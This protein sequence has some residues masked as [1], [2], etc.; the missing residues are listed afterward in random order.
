MA[1]ALEL[2][3][4]EHKGTKIVTKRN[5]VPVL[6]MAMMLDMD[7]HQDL[8]KQ[9]GRKQFS[10]PWD[11][12]YDVLPLEEQQK[13]DVTVYQ[14]IYER[15]LGRDFV[16]EPDEMPCVQCDPAIAHIVCSAFTAAPPSV[17]IYLSWEELQKLEAAFPLEGFEHTVPCDLVR[18][19]EVP[20]WNVELVLTDPQEKTATFTVV[21][22]R[23]DVENAWNRGIRGGI[24][25]MF[26]DGSGICQLFGVIPG[27]NQLCI[28]TGAAPYGHGLDCTERDLWFSLSYLMHVWYLVQL[29]CMHPA[30]FASMQTVVRARDRRKLI[31]GQTPLRTVR[32]VYERTFFWDVEQQG[33]FVYHPGRYEQG[34]WMPAQW[35]AT[36]GTDLVGQIAKNLS[37]YNIQQA[38]HRAKRILL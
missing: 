37:E 36:D 1:K 19:F 3:T 22:L 25:V 16:S 30:G 34:I 31:T 8:W 4:S 24:H 29:G 14:T 26:S 35:E 6:N 2:L 28:Q 21:A 27:L 9:V 23:A 10:V 32:N 33:S 18:S 15:L 12:T 5:T 17:R 11:E 38:L 7:L 20:F 13:R